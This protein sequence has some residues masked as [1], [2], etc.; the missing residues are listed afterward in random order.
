[1]PTLRRSSIHQ[2]S[3]SRQ[4]IGKPSVAGT[5]TVSGGDDSLSIAFTPASGRKAGIQ[6]VVTIGRADL[7]LLVREALAAWP[8]DGPE[9]TRR[10]VETMAAALVTQQTFQ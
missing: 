1:M 10:I 3:A 9:L 6:L 8:E 5:L 2:A 4:M 7:G